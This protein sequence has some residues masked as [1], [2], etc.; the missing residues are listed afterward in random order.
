MHRRHIDVYDFYFSGEPS[1]ARPIAI[2][3]TA[4]DAFQ[5]TTTSE[6]AGSR[7]PLTLELCL[8]VVHEANE[9]LLPA[10]FTHSIVTAKLCQVLHVWS[11]VVLLTH[12]KGQSG[13]N[14]VS[15]A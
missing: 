11:H 10:P 12:T 9:A 1:S 2:L 4:A 5:Q 6:S 15:G 8:Q 13:I 7:A 3:S 14:L